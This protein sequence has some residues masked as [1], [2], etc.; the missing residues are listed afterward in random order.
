MRALILGGGIAG[1]ATAHALAKHGARVTL[2]EQGPLP[3]PLSSSF[4]QHRLIRHVY[5]EAEGYCRMVE[6]AFAA[7]ERLWADLGAR[8][9][10]ETGAL[11]ISDAPGDWTERSARTLDRLGIPWDR[12]D[13]PVLRDRYPVLELTDDAWS[14]WTQAGGALLADRILA[15]LVEACARAGVELVAGVAARR[16]DPESAQVELADGRRLAADRLVVTAGAWTAKLLPQL[17]HRFRPHRQALAYVAAPAEQAPVW[18]RVPILVDLGGTDDL[19]VVPPVSGTGLKFGAGAHK[20]PGDPDAPRLPEP[21]E[22]ERILARFQ[23]RIA[24]LERY[25][26]ERLQL[27]HY[28]IAPDRRFVAEALGPTLAVSACSGHGFKF[29]A[30][31]G[32]RVAETVASGADPAPFIRWAAGY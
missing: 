20:R 28:M 11:A 27:C 3:N 24:A 22:G 2:V 30:L 19:Y 21:G 32:E 14:I 4:D 29:G 17:S 16:V 7:W 26:V 25:R 23:G 1:L 15:A 8:H 6:D 5:A 13:A 31:M 9:Y 12:I 10:V 18:E